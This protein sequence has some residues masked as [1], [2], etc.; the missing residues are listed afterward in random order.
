MR[1][2]TKEQLGL[3][4]SEERGKLGASEPEAE[5]L[6][7]VLVVM[8]EVPCVHVLNVQTPNSMVIVQTESR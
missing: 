1:I 5:K 8:H 6:D 2:A 3:R 7:K 4:D